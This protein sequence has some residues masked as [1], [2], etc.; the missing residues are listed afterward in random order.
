[1]NKNLLLIIK[2]NYNNIIKNKNKKTLKKKT[3]IY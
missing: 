2:I 1:M 3:Y